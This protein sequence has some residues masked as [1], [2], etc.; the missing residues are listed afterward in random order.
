MTLPNIEDNINEFNGDIIKKII[1]NIDNPTHIQT[2]CVDFVNSTIIKEEDIVTIY[3][4]FN[5]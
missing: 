5:F 1:N 3:L 2:F 4:Y